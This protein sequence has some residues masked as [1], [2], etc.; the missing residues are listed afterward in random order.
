MKRIVFGVC[1]L[2]LFVALPVFAQYEDEIEL[3]RAIIQTER[4]AIVTAAMELDD[5]QRDAFW[6]LYREYRA[7]RETVGDRR[8]ALIT[9]YAKNY[10]KLSSA[11]AEQM[12]DEF[13]R[14]QTEDLKLRKKYVKKFR[15]ILPPKQ[16]TLFFQLENKLDTVIDHEIAAEVPLVQ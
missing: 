15:M 1:A 8:V 16:V 12:L 10:E 11:Q 2:A 14:F 9:D 7:A 13:L 4:Q 5:S 6:P 3:T